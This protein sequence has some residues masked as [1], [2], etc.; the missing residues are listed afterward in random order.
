MGLRSLL[1]TARSSVSSAA[2]NS[3]A[4]A[5]AAARR[6]RDAA[7]AAKARADAARRQAQNA[8]RREAQEAAAR[9]RAAAR[10]AKDRA[11]SAARSVV[12]TVDRT[13]NR[14]RAS[15]SNAVDKVDDILDDAV[16]G[17]QNAARSTFSGAKALG[18]GLAAGVGAAAAATGLDDFEFDFVDS[19]DEVQER[20]DR[21]KESDNPLAKVVGNVAN[22]A[23]S[24]LGLDAGYYAGLQADE[25]AK[26]TQIIEDDVAFYQ[27]AF[28]QDLSASG[29]PDPDYS[30]P[31]PSQDGGSDVPDVSSEGLVSPDEIVDGG[32]TG[33][34]LLGAV[35]DPLGI[36]EDYAVFST[37]ENPDGTEATAADKVSAGLGL[38]AKGAVVAG[39]GYLGYLGVRKVVSK[40]PRKKGVMR[41]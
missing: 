31:D 22:I 25:A 3:R 28:T 11:E 29:V 13:T 5:E 6:A 33:S 37:G 32:G 39:T 1:R 20:I 18:T 40:I 26:Q 8:A 17:V 41:P 7:R 2:R 12:R 10:E 36:G 24:F 35:P 16:D 27:D 4:A 9:A 15:A 19:I 30:G 38:G 34:A 14:A 23:T 21:F